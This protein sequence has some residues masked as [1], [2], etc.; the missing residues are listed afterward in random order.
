MAYCPNSNEYLRMECP[1]R[2][3]GTLSEAFL[4]E[5]GTFLDN[6]AQYP[7]NWR[8]LAWNLLQSTAREMDVSI[9][10]YCNVMYWGNC[11]GII[12][13]PTISIQEKSH[14]HKFPSRSDL[15]LLVD[16]LGLT[17]M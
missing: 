1:V 4:V 11:P 7:G 8:G 15:P 10:V 17:R 5:L 2:G 3:T 12:P 14:L 9:K 13:N 16:G 6:D